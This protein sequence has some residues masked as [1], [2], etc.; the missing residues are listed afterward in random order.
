MSGLQM[1]L[2]SPEGRKP[3]LHMNTT[4][5]PSGAGYKPA[6]LWWYWFIASNY[7]GVHRESV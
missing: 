4:S 3:S 5:D 6:V 2:I 1:A 7:Q